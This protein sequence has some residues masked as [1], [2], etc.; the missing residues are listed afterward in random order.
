MT[1]VSSRRSFVGV[2][3]LAV[4]G[5]AGWQIATC[6]ANEEADA[7]SLAINRPWLERVPRGER[8][9]V[10][11]FLLLDHPRARIGLLGRSSRW[12]H[13]FELF[14]WAL[15][16]ERLQLHF[17]Q[18]GNKE[19]RTVRV[20][21]CEGEAP[22]PFDLCLELVADGGSERYYSRG[23]WKIEPRDAAAS[24]AELRQDVPELAGVPLP[25]GT[26][27]PGWAE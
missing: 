23:D 17:P 27:D 22:R 7:A 6:G 4:C 13:D 1:T 20:R 15:E 5:L 14:R 16:A 26:D 21:R 8:D 3:V 12:R 24:L 11:H 10:A 2:V 25:P 9:V 18:S 19:K